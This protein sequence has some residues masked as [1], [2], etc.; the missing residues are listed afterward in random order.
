MMQDLYQG[1]QYHVKAK[2][3]GSMRKI[4]YNVVIVLSSNTGFVQNASCECKASSLGR[5]SH[6][7]AVLFAIDDCKNSRSD[8]SCTSKPCTWNVGRKVGKNPKSITDAQYPN[9]KRKMSAVINFDP[10]PTSLRRTS[11][12]HV[13]MNNFVRDL[14]TASSPQGSMWETII[15]MHFDNY[16]LSIDETGLLQQKVGIICQNLMPSVSGVTELCSVQGDETWFAERRL[17]VTASIAKSVVTAS[18][19]CVRANLVKRKLWEPPVKAVS[20]EYDHVN[21]AKARQSFVEKFPNMTVRETGLWV[22][23]EYPYLAASPD[24][25]LHD[26]DLDSHGVLEIKCPISLKEAHPK[27]FYTALSKKQ[28]AGFCLKVDGDEV[29]MSKKHAYYYQV[30]MQMGVL[31][32]EWSY[33]VIWSP[34]GMIVKK[35]LF[36]KD[37]FDAM[38]PVLRNFHCNYLCPEY[39]EMRLPRHLPIL[40]LN[41]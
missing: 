31:Q 2:V 41:Y 1:N 40:S 38:V 4:T 26:R 20:L 18:S 5:C 7:A 24:G 28:L 3:L 15:P 17:R 29:T 16:T 11:L 23:S 25:L 10:R 37:F 21:E 30:Q 33:F 35:I 39:V 36:D 34:K 12:T 8:E 13:E 32:R 14:Q 27:D 9:R 6:V 22:N 19:D